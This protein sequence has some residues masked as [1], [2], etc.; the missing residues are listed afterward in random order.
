[1]KQEGAEPEKNSVGGTGGGVRKA[2]QDTTLSGAGRFPANHCLLALPLVLAPLP[3]GGG[4][5][6]GGDKMAQGAE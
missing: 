3:R 5:R 1:M 4:G 6:E 2:A